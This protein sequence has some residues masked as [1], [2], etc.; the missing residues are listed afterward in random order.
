MANVQNVNQ[1]LK[2]CKYLFYFLTL[3]YLKFFVEYVIK[4]I[5]KIKINLVVINSIKFNKI[6]IMGR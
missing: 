1:L 6:Q 4:S 2:I 3:Q 5:N